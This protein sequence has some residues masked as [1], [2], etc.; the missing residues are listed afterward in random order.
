MIGP[1]VV[2]GA[3]SAPTL[4]TNSAARP[5][6]ANYRWQFLTDAGARV[7]DDDKQMVDLVRS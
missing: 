6:P 4:P 2:I 3:P 1:N 5:A 7:R